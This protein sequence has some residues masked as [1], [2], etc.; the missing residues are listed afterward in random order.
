MLAHERLAR[1]GHG[2]GWEEAV[3]RAVGGWWRGWSI[4]DLDRSGSRVMGRMGVRRHLMPGVWIGR[5]H[6]VSGMRISR[7]GVVAGVGIAHGHGV[8]CMSASRRHAVACMR[9][10]RRGGLRL[11]GA[12]ED[13]ARED[14]ALHAARTVT[15][16]NMPACM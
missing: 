5:R 2:G 13:Q 14:Q 4:A 1:G 8:P 12:G 9:I 10:S 11:G 6:F 15:I 16:S 3:R 7:R